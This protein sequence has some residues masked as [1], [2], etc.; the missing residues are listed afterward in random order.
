MIN[1]RLSDKAHHFLFQHAASLIKDE[2][3]TYFPLDIPSGFTHLT[4]S[5]KMCKTTP[6]KVEKL[7]S[8]IPMPSSLG[9]K[10]D[11]GSAQVVAK[12]FL[13]VSVSFNE[14]GKKLVQAI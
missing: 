13:V 3:L 4:I 6:I 8:K 5:S 9:M 7:L 14:K 2:K 1:I 12:R 10:V 11:F